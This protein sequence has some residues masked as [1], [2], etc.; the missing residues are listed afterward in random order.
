MRVRGSKCDRGKLLTKQEV[1]N[2]TQGPGWVT[3]RDVNDQLEKAECDHIFP[4][5]VVDITP[6]FL[7]PT[8]LPPGHPPPSRE[9]QHRDHT[10]SARTVGKD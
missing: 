5:P 8:A 10:P 3:E 7:R 6:R 1:V 4:P 9:T 2:E